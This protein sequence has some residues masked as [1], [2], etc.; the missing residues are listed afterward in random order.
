MT[1]LKCADFGGNVLELQFGTTVCR[2]SVVLLETAREGETTGSEKVK[3]R[4][5]NAFFSHSIHPT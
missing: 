1:N 4:H 5:R 2:F 3:K